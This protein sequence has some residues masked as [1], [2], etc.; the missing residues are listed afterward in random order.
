MTDL[1]T[2]AVLGW[3]AAAARVAASTPLVSRTPLVS[4]SLFAQLLYLVCGGL[5]LSSVLMLW[6]RQLSALI[7]LLTVQGVLLGAMAALLGTQ[8]GG[9]CWQRRC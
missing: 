3:A 8:D 7:G 5:L 4:S 2:D 9:P 6:R 1:L